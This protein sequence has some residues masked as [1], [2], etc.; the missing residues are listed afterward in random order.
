MDLRTQSSLLNYEKKVV[1]I[2][3]TVSLISRNFLS[4]FYHIFEV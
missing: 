4:Q 3:S 1:E 2:T